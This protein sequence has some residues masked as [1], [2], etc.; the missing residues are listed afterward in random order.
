MVSSEE[1][2]KEK[3]HSYPFLLS[4]YKLKLEKEEVLMI[5]DNFK[6]DIL[7]AYNI[8]IKSIWLNLKN[9][10]FNYDSDYIQEVKSFNKILNIL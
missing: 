7:G 9:E 4:L 10:S 6:K 1:A 2:G 8:G 3:P 5:G